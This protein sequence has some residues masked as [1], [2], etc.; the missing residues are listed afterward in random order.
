VISLALDA[1]F[2]DDL[3]LAAGAEAATR[4]YAAIIPSLGVGLGVP[5]RLYP[6]RQVGLRAQL[7]VHWP[8][9]GWVTCFDV[10]PAA[11]LSA[12]RRFQVA[13]LAQLGL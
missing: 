4:S 7:T 5:L 12:P 11:D 13:L 6:E 10:Y 8:F 1:S 9:L 2:R 3:V